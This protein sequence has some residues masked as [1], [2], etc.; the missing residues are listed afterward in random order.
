L[1]PLVG[2]L[3]QL[4]FV[5]IQYPSE[6]SWIGYDLPSGAFIQPSP[7]DA[8][9]TGASGNKLHWTK[10][11]AALSP[12]GRG[13]GR[14]RHEGVKAIPPLTSMLL[15]VPSVKGIKGGLDAVQF[16]LLPVSLYFT[17]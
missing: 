8:F 5:S 2:F 11:Y 12:H 9:T 7:D 16:I 10:D 17:H 3:S 13:H 14:R 1:S 6:A 15:M 4:P